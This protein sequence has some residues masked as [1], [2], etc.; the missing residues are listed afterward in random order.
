MDLK[1]NTVPEL[2]D[3]IRQG[4]MIILLDSADRENEGDLVI[5]AEKVTQKHINFMAKNARGL[6][7]LALSEKIAARLKLKKM[8]ENNQGQH[9]TNFTVSIEA[10][11]GVTTGI[12]ARDRAITIQK[13]VAI[14]SSD[15]DIVS[16][17][18][19]FPII[20][21][22]GG[23]LVRAGHTEAGC[24]IANLAGLQ[25]ASVIVE[26]MKE[27]G[28][29]ARTEDLFQFAKKFALKIGTIESLIQH[30]LETANVIEKVMQRPIATNYGE[31]ELHCYKN[32]IKNTY[33][34][35]LT[36]GSIAADK[37]TLVR[38]HT[39]N[40]M[41]DLLAVKQ[42]IGTNWSFSN[43]LKHIANNGNGIALLLDKPENINDS[44]F[45]Y[46]V[47][48]PDKTL[49]HYD[50]LEVGIGSQI[51]AD[52][53]AKKIKLLSNPVNYNLSG[54]GLE[55]TEIINYEES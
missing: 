49:S 48:Q 24:D 21:K 32:L 13:A 18:H 38:V 10:R 28:T 43:A 16:P 34:Y 4:K 33:N 31:F 29:M 14:N 45:N 27:D 35:A 36:M 7:C 47:S 44:I 3:D 39:L 15:K 52:L 9:G 53:G 19:I 40:A 17:G 41:R 11:T 54:Y 23:V 55:V 42:S 22:K 6:I 20:A 50:N 8:V 12:S 46:L 2:I 26:V 5:A 1:F 30:Q 25:S 37:E 51:V